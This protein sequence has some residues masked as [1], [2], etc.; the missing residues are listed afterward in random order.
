MAE[1]QLLMFYR[2][3]NRLVV[4][5]PVLSNHMMETV[6]QLILVQQLVAMADTSSV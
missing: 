2:V 6:D 1:W 3:V 4:F 5:M